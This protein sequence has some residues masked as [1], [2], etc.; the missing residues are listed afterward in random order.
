MLFLSY[1]FPNWVSLTSHNLPYLPRPLPVIV[2]LSPFFYLP[3][4]SLTFT[5][6]ILCHTI[7]A[8]LHPPRLASHIYPLLLLFSPFAYNVSLCRY[9]QGFKLVTRQY[10]ETIK[11]RPQVFRIT[12]F[13]SS[14]I[15]QNELKAERS[16]SFTDVAVLWSCLLHYLFSLYLQGLK[17]SVFYLTFF[18]WATN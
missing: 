5:H 8:L 4:E 12:S 17:G 15:T 18:Y 10:G 13:L 7:P 3:P 9:G 6:N 16:P 1:V 2:F 11:V 14:F